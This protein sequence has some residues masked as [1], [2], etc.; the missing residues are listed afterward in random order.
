MTRK[1]R[2]TWT[3]GSTSRQTFGLGLQEQELKKKMEEKTRKK[4]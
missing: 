2:K 1:A 4:Q 3:H